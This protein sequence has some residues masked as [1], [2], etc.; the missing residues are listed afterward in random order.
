MKH[1]KLLTLLLFVFALTI[2]SCEKEED[3]PIP[4][5]PKPVMTIEFQ[6]DKTSIT[7]PSESTID[8]QITFKAEKDIA[9]VYY[10][11][12]QAGGTYIEKDITLKMGPNHTDMALNKPEAVYYFQVNAGELNTL[13]ATL[14]TAVYTFTFKDSEDNETSADF[15][16]KKESGTY[17]TKEIT[18]GELYHIAGSL[19]GGWDLDNDTRVTTSGA[20]NTMFM[21]NT[22]VST[23]TG[24]WKSNP[25]NACKFVKASSSFNYTT[26]TEEAASGA[27]NAGSQS[28]SVT[29]P[30]ANDMYIA[31]KNNVYYVIKILN[32]DPTYSSGT[33]S[34]AGQMTFSYKKKP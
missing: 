13:M 27:F 1:L 24:S 7:Y 30:Q 33:G 29:N 9:R 26:A 14:T 12:P 8:V 32:V 20:P 23:F 28:T 5:P 4:D 19:G 17:L 15:T 2:V 31:M 22:D 11:Q 16:I 21:T 18:N 34:N 25:A 6:G 3:P 10:Q